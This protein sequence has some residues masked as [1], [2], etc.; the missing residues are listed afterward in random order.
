MSESFLELPLQ[1]DGVRFKSTSLMDS[2]MSAVNTL[3]STPRGSVPCD[4]EFGAAQLSPDKSLVELASIKDE[5]ARTIKD[6]LEKNEPR[7][8]KISVKVQGGLK[9]DKS[10]VAPLR[11]E[12]S[13]EIASTGQQF[14][15]EKLLSEDYYRAPFPGRVG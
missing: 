10:G 5:L 2:L 8:D 1:F 11:I 12:I 15:L 13:G 6:T 14:K 9:P 7:L 3:V 4:P